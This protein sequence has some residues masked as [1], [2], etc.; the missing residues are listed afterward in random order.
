MEVVTGAMGS[1]LP[2]LGQLLM[3]EYNLHKRVKKDVE[4]LWKELESMHA[5][6]IKV[7]EVPRDQLD[8]Q[9][10][11]WADE[12]RELSYNME[13]VVDKFLVRVEGIQQPHDNTSRFKE[14][15]NK[16]IYLF[17]KG[18]NHHRIAGA[19]KEIKEQLQE[20][21][22]RRGRNKLDEVMQH[23]QAIQMH[24]GMLHIRD[25]QGPK[26]TGTVE[27]ILEAMEKEVFWQAASRL[28]AARMRLLNQHPGFAGRRRG[29]PAESASPARLAAAVVRLLDLVAQQ[30]GG[31][32]ILR[33]VVLTGLRCGA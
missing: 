5:A 19:I 33:G 4:F 24:E 1:L 9:V 30:F 32:G 2:K 27:A 10:K 15:K 12:V 14:L 8:R 11:L 23:P 21:A 28:T 20:V 18:K 29:P 16:M 6:L 26:G 22:A 7:G 25:V 13:D 3:D 17:K 31:D